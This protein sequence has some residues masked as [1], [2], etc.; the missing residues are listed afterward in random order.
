MNPQLLHSATMPVMC[1]HYFPNDRMIHAMQQPISWLPQR[2]SFLVWLWAHGHMA[3]CPTRAPQSVN[4]LTFTRAAN[5]GMTDMHL[6]V[7]ISNG[8]LP[9]PE[10]YLG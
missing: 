3:L 6:C 5:C 4:I 7:T 2:L 8:L 9:V 1:L 10:I